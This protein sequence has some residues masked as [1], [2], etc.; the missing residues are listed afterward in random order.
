MAK[1]FCFDFNMHLGFY[2]QK[3]IT[4]TVED[5]ILCKV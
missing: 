4:I 5:D 1:I 3:L 2:T